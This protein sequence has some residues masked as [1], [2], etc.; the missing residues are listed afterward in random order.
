MRVTVRRCSVPLS[1]E[2]STSYICWLETWDTTCFVARRYSLCRVFFFSHLTFFLERNSKKLY[3][4]RERN[5]NT[6]HACIFSFPG[7]RSAAD[8]LQRTG[9]TEG[10]LSWRFRA[11]K[12]YFCYF[13]YDGRFLL[14][15]LKNVLF[16]PKTHVV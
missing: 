14:F 5:G 7:M 4:Y 16:N 10:G 2:Q 11:I 1:R 8:P 6:V 3:F 13:I 15:S 9:S 12:C